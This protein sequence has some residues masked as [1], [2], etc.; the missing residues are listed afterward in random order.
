M[1]KR[2]GVV[3]VALAAVLAV[4]AVGAA[5]APASACYKVSEFSS[6]TKGGNYKELLCK[7]EITSAAEDLKA[8][9][10]LATIL[11]KLTG[12]LWC[13]SLLLSTSEAFSLQ[14]YYT[15]ST[16]ATALTGTST[17]HSDWTAVEVLP[18]LSLTLC[19]SCYPL[20]LDATLLNVAT[21]LSSSSGVALEGVGFLL[22]LLTEELTSLG[23]FEALFTKVKDPNNG[24]ECNTAGDALGEL[25]LRGTF[26]IVYTS[27]S[28]LTLG[29]LYLVA[30]VALTCG[31]LTIELKGSLLS[32]LNGAGTEDTEL[33]SVLSALR[34]N[35]KGKPSLTTYYNDE[36]AA[37]KAKLEAEL[38]AGFVETALEVAAEVTLLALKTNMF[39]I[40]NR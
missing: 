25:L 36:G 35:G 2:L 8:E 5:A 14:G 23:T 16:C 11:K 13:A 1:I 3:V 37:K 7:T 20:H 4:S 24:S 31:T 15:S 9:F 17:N 10:V 22:L 12:N 6:G 30:P 26:H 34:G 29:I 33:I 19:A 18:D 27:L 28:P 21:D 38:G 40:T 39:V 32:P